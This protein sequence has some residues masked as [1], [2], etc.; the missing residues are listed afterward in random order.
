MT[1]AR[2]ATV[3]VAGIVGSA[4]L[5]SVFAPDLVTGSA[6]DHLPIGAL[7]TWPLALVAIG[8]VLMASPAGGLDRRSFAI[9]LTWLVAAAVGVLGPELVTGTDPTH[10]PLATILAPVVA[11]VITG[12]ACI[13]AR[14]R[15]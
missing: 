10:V 4:A 11:V 8:Y 9:G 5:L 3:A 6:H 1:P 2:P 13:A 14:R 15:T 7:V 12:F